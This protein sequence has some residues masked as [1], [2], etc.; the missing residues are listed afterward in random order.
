MAFTHEITF[1]TTNEHILDIL[2]EDK[3]SIITLDNN[4]VFLY[5][6]GDR[7]NKILL[8]NFRYNNKIVSQ[9]FYQDNEDLKGTWLP[10]DGIKA[11][12]NENNEFFQ[13]FDVSAFET[14]LYPFGDIKL[15][16]VSYLLGGG[17]WCNKT[18]K[19]RKMLNVNERISYIAD[20]EEEKV[21]F[22]NSLYINHFIN[23]SISR[24]YYNKHPIS[25]FRPKSPKWIT[26]SKEI[27]NEQKLFSAFDF[28]SKMNNSYQIEYTPPVFENKTK[29]EHY[30]NLYEKIDN[31][32]VKDNKATYK[33]CIIL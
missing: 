24:N 20:F 14:D 23:Y 8:V 26:N 27:K 16:A 12:V 17:V 19:Y 25:S 11:N 28:S 30:K 13:Y 18:Q 22:N 7:K 1:T 4:T 10:C 2:H 15:M 33:M 6:N 5:I 3:I 21:E 32:N 9:A 29:R 31:S